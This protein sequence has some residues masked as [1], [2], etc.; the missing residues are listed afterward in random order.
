VI[1]VSFVVFVVIRC[2]A[3]VAA[4]QEKPP[5]ADN[6]FKNVQLLRGIPVKEFISPGPRRHADRRRSRQ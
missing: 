5:M 3:T 4:Q 2:V 6:V 1:F